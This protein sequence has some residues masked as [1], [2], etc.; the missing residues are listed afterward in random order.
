MTY[1]AEI[2]AGLTEEQQRRRDAIRS[3]Y[4]RHRRMRMRRLALHFALLRWLR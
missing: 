2:P 1:P 4:A 3:H